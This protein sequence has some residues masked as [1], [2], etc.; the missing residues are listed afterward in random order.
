MTRIE[1][2]T[3]PRGGPRAA[4]RP[5]SQTAMSGNAIPWAR[6]G[7]VTMA[8]GSW[9]TRIGFPARLVLVLIGVTVLELKLT[10]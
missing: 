1:T 8:L 4:E 2:R 3:E 9:G 6:Q 5:D 7:A 10:R